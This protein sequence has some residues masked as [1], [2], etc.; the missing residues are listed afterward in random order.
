MPGYFVTLVFLVSLFAILLAVFLLCQY[1]FAFAHPNLVFTRKTRMNRVR[2]L[3]SMLC[4]LLGYSFEPRPNS[5]AL[6]IVGWFV[7]DHRF[8]KRMLAL[9]TSLTRENNID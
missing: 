6:G 1:S 4:M 9:E 3:L 8:I 2:S 7:F 5:R